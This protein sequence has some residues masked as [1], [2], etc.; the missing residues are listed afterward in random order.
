MQRPIK[1][2]AAANS[3]LIFHVFVQDSTST[4]GA[5]KASVAFGSW[6]CYYI[7]SGEAISGAITPQDI[8]T[9]GTYAAPTANTNIRIK[10]VDNT[11]MI[12]VYEIQLHMDWMNTTNTCQ[13]I[14]IYLTASGVAVLPIQIPLVATDPQDAVRG[15]MTALPNANADAAGG[16]PISDAGGLDLDARLDAAVTSRMASYTQPTG[17]LAATFPTGTVANTTNITAGTM[18]TT[19][20]LTTNN[21][22]TGYALSSAGVTAIWAEVMDGTRTAVQAM[23][24]FI[25]AM[26]GKASGLDTNAP[27]YRNIADTKN[28]I[29]A[30]TDADGNRTAVT[31]DLT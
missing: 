25:A 28:V 17:F 8:T 15:G 26:L 11:N 30:T 16:L 21:D 1:R 9:I 19:T 22:K 4:T 29:D 2:G 14:T 24:G 7:R 31:L 20:N 6:T 12:G 5:G 23:R 13:S 18:T 27:K 10:A 3:G